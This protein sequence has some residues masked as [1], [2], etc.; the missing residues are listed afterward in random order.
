MLQGRLTPDAGIASVIRQIYT[1]RLSGVLSVERWPVAK[2]LFFAK[3]SISF[4]ETNEPGWRLGEL[5]V[6][7]NLIRSADLNDDCVVGTADLV[8]LLTAWG[9]C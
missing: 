3:G 5:L 6:A 2:R 9:P 4:S 8:I 1:N 7:R